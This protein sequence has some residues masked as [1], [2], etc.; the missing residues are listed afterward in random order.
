M[1]FRDPGGRRTWT[2]PRRASPEPPWGAMETRSPG[3]PAEGEDNGASRRRWRPPRARAGWPP[4]GCGRALA[5]VTCLLGAPTRGGQASALDPSLLAWSHTG[6]LD[7]RGASG[8][9]LG[10]GVRG[11]CSGACPGQTLGTPPSLEVPRRCREGADTRDCRR[12]PLGRRAR[13][14]RGRG[15]VR[16]QRVALSGCSEP[17]WGHHGL[18]A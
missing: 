3:G 5:A 9:R 6:D 4:H 11:R 16:V 18:V 7:S 12:S 2:S 13:R 10:V 8:S 17:G 1:A 15:E 14:E